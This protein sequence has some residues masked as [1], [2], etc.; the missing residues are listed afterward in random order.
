[1]PAS[2]SSVVRPGLEV[3]S[4]PKASSPA[5]DVV[6]ADAQTQGDEDGGERVQDVVDGRPAQ[7][8]GGL[9]DREEP[10]D[11]VRPPDVKRPV[12]HPRS[13]PAERAGPDPLRDR[14]ID[15]EGVD[16]HVARLAPG[17]QGR[18][19]E[20]EDESAAVQDR[21]PDDELRLDEVLEGVHPELPEMV[22]RHVEHRHGFGTRHA[23]TAPQQ[24]AARGLEHGRVDV[25]VAQH[26]PG[27]AGSGV[28]APLEDLVADLDAVG[29]RDAGRLP[30]R[31][32]HRGDDTYRGRL[33]V[34]AGHHGERHVVDLLPVQRLGVRQLVD[35]EPAAARA[36]ADRAAHGIREE[37]DPVRGGRVAQPQQGRARLLPDL[38]DEAPY[39]L[40]AWRRGGA[41]E[42]RP[43]RRE[44][45]LVHL[46]RGVERVDRRRQDEADAPREASA[47]E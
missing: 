24:A 36:R 28:V 19:V 25:R 29:R 42:V 7:R 32:E 12:F 33:A 11:A 21:V 9:V 43:S 39:L 30:G 31:L 6:R 40:V 34:R 35:V 22:L 47:V 14:G 4:R 46:G 23:E 1:M 16:L 18:I 27:A 2:S 26:P 41:H 44:G 17:E 10:R 3:A 37:Q 5:A 13:A 38:V 8:H 20:T 15:R 45:R